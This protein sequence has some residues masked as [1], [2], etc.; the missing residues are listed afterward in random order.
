MK[1]QNAGCGGHDDAAQTLQEALARISAEIS[2]VDGFESVA[3][4]DALDRVL[5]APIHSTLDVPAHTNSAMDGYA[6]DGAQLPG[7]GERSFRVIGTP[8][9]GGPSTAS[10]A[11]AS[12]CAS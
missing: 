11:R 6:L 9:P 10:P 2:P 5:Y 1:H 4:R 3:T 12:A 8:G 7:E